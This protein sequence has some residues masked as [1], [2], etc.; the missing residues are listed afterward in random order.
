LEE[1]KKNYKGNALYLLKNGEEI[2]VEDDKVTVIG[3][4]RIIKGA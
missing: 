1:I 4:E 2:I 3:E